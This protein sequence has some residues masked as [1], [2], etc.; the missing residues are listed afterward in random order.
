[1][2][3]M[4]TYRQ[5]VSIRPHARRAGD[6]ISMASAC[7]L[8]LYIRI[9]EYV[10]PIGPSNETC[11][12]TLS[13]SC[14]PKSFSV[15]LS[16]RVVC[17]HAIQLES[18]LFDPAMSLSILPS[19]PPRVPAQSLPYIPRSLSP[20]FS[21]IL[22]LLPSPR[23][24]SQNDCYPTSSSPPTKIPPRPTKETREKVL[25]VKATH[26]GQHPQQTPSS[27]QRAKTNSQQ[28]AAPRAPH[29]ERGTRQIVEGAS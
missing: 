8:H 6:R 22:A 29:C 20:I 2:R 15:S 27:Q 18:F 7:R 19:A 25:D 12:N 23:S 3:A 11:I 16:P 4:G 13:E 21:L 26:V 9:E 1:M 28:R 17:G 14:V 5:K 24:K 10:S